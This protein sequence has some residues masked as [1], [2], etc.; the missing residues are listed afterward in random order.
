MIDIPNKASRRYN[1]E[2]AEDARYLLR[3]LDEL[4]SNGKHTK[5]TR[6]QMQDLRDGVRA[7]RILSDNAAL[8]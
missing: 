7:E 4:L 5:L 6:Q 1:V 3:V 8:W 2:R